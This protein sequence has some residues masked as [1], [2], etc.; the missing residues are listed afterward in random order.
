MAK[1]EV[2]LN[3]SIRREIEREV[4][5]CFKTIAEDVCESVAKK[6]FNDYLGTKINIE[7]EKH[8][9]NTLEKQIN[10]VLKS[11]DLVSKTDSEINA[12]SVKKFL[13]SIDHDYHLIIDEPTNIVYEEYY[14]FCC[15]NKIPTLDK[16]WFSRELKRQTGIGSRVTTKGGKSIRIY[17]QEVSN[18]K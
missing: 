15:E 17:T 3:E 11:H 7:V 16:Q 13:D 1:I 12:Q 5:K 10:L 8:L 18:D 2:E 9:N 6:Y 4:L 14:E